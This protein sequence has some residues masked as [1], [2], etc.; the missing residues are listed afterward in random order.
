MTF[1]RGAAILAA[2]T[3]YEF[4]KLIRLPGYAAPILAFPVMFYIIFGL[5]FGGGRAAGSTTMASYLIATMGSFGVIGAAMF[6]LGVSV[7]GERGQG[8]LTVKRASPMPMLSYLTAKI[9]I[10]MLFSAIIVTILF[11]LG[12]VFG[13][14]RLSVGAAAALAASLVFGAI[15]FCALG[16]G[17]GYLAGPN[18]AQPIVNLLYLPMAFAS[19]LWMPLEILPK[20]IQHLAPFLPPYHL[21]QLALSVTGFRPAA[22]VATHVIALAGFTAVF[23]LL[24]AIGYQRDEGKTY[25]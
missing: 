9:L 21:A 22:D 19:G 5:S 6:G 3:K 25:G 20:F 4:L 16:L 12:A 24:A 17:I 7:A 13:N 18:S 2:E 15:P 8:W 10:A 23:L 11:V 14:V 1:A